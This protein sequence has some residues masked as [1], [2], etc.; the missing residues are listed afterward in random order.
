MCS[1]RMRF[2]LGAAVWLA[3]CQDYPFE[4]RESRRSQVHKVSEVVLTVRPTDI[5]FVVDTSGTMEEERRL[6]R[7][8][9]ETFLTALLDSATDFQIGLI[10]TDVECNVPERNCD[11]FSDPVNK[12]LASESCCL[13]RAGIFCK[14]EDTD[15][16]GRLD[17][18]DCDAGRLRSATGTGR[19][20][21]PPGPLEDRAAWIASF[22]AAVDS[23]D[24][25]L[26]STPIKPDGSGFE[27]GLEAAVRAVG[28]A[29][30]QACPDPRVAELNEGFVRPGADLVLVFI[31]DEDD[32]SFTDP[33]RYLR[34]AVPS[35]PLE[36]RDHL[37]SPTEC[38]AYYGAV[39]PVA[40]GTFRCSGFLRSVAPPEPDPVGTFLDALT[41]FTGNDVRRIR[42]AGIVSSVADS[43]AR[44]GFKEAGCYAAPSG[45][46]A[47]CGCIA[48]SSEDFFCRL[49]EHLG[50]QSTRIPQGGGERLLCHAPVPNLGGCEAAPSRRYVQFL[51]EL[52]DRR[53][54]AGA[55]EDVLIDSI[56]Q[57]RYD[58]TLFRIVNNVILSNCFDLGMVPASPDVVQVRR[59]GAIVPNVEPD[60]LRQ[61]WSWIQ[62]SREICLEGGLR[63]SVND[64][65]EIFVL[66]S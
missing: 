25:D 9:I 45:P 58:D 51:R 24:C 65:F 7:E 42:A 4:Y 44:L 19:I 66:S 5:L 22:A 49:T 8:N 64:R 13:R 12:P 23:L 15:G 31:T 11:D 16:D 63:K 37:C 28:C 56:C 1:L 34:P 18:T 50:Q 59:N 6:V 46:S 10:T 2:L 33:T 47:V 14:D 43:S 62:G 55:R 48:T 41:H 29:A 52:A 26:S 57:P 32:C 36:Q 30:G 17:K 27:A 21:R 20:F 53:L 39:D 40:S 61:G 38:Y 54:A 35:S 60:S 3:A